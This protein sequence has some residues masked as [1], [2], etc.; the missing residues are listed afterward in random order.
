MNEHPNNPMH[1]DEPQGFALPPELAE[2]CG[3]LEL[4]AAADRAAAGAAFEQR[5]AASTLP[6]LPLE[7]EHMESLAHAERHAASPSLEDRIFVATRALLNRPAVAAAVDTDAPA[8][9]RIHT[10]SFRWALRAAAVLAL[11]V[12]GSV[13]YVANQSPTTPTKTG[14]GNSIARN[15]PSSSTEIAKQ[16]E[17]DF[18]SL[19]T[20]LNVALGS[21]TE[22]NLTTTTSSESS[23]LDSLELPRLDFLENEVEGSI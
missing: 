1:A 11:G 14:G 15:T 6:G 23:S 19:G 9:I 7:S 22:S 8:P 17:N 20:I 18:Q 16:L 12:G 4:L 5:L 2:V 21:E 13:L 10:R 3:S